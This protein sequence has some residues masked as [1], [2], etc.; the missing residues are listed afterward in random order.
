MQLFVWLTFVFFMSM[1][2]SIVVFIIN[3]RWINQKM[4]LLMGVSVGVVLATT[5]WSLLVPS[6]EYNNNDF[7]IMLS[8]SL[9]YII[10][11]MIELLSVKN[12][13]TN[14][15]G[16][17]YLAITLHNIPEGLIIGL[18]FGAM[19]SVTNSFSA[20]ALAFAIGIQ[21]FPESIS[22]SV[23]LKERK[24]SRNKIIMLSFV[25]A[26]VEPVFGV[27]GYILSYYIINMIGLI[28]G[29]TAGMM[30]FVVISEMIVNTLKGNK[31]IGMIG[32]LIGFVI[33]MILE[34][35]L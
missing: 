34:K 21:N 26:A 16:E 33:I 18:G 10:L 13:K 12:N 9:G 27:L 24:I 8:F 29:F 6:F 19:Q 30:L 22:L 20:I 14:F 23:V 5:I 15:I 3:E 25:S 31:I 32:I 35:I 28:M 2:G 4:P 1:I 7:V 11:L 17:T